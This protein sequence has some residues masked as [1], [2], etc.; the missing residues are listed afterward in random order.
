M[1]VILFHLFGLIHTTEKSA[2]LV[3][4][5][6]CICTR[7]IYSTHKLKTTERQKNDDKPQRD[8]ICGNIV[9]YFFLLLRWAIY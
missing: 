1:L 9:M 6:R 5:F 8:T 2:M 4:T 3:I 7:G